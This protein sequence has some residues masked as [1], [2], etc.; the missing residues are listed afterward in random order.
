M[1]ADD[2]DEKL[3][4]AFE[5]IL[6]GVEQSEEKVMDYVAQVTTKFTQATQSL[7]QVVDGISEFQ[8]AN[9]S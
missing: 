4:G 8:P 2:L 1:R 6:K 3:G 5:R 7:Q 9:K